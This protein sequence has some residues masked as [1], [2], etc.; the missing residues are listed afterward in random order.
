MRF[1]LFAA[2]SAPANSNPNDRDILFRK[3]LAN[4]AIEQIVTGAVDGG[5]P[6][7]G[8]AVRVQE[9]RRPAACAR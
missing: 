4:D 7:V 9:G 8:Q 3:V 2:T 5:A 1:A 6:G